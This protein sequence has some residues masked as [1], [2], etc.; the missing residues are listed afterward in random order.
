MLRDALERA[1]QEQRPVLVLVARHQHVQYMRSI[2]HDVLK[3]TP[4]DLKKIHIASPYELPRGQRFA[5]LFVDH[6]VIE[7][8]GVR[9]SDWLDRAE[10]LVAMTNPPKLSCWA[11]LRTSPYT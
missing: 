4:D 3:V 10:T 1:R 2:L 9:T 6:F 7:T 5:A 8:L 11:R